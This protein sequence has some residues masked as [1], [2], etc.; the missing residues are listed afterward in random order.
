MEKLPESRRRDV[1]A[2]D[3]K[4]SSSDTKRDAPTI[5]VYRPHIHPRTSLI[6]QQRDKQP[7][8]TLHV[9]FTRKTRTWTNRG[10]S[11]TK[12]L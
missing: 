1:C 11:E 7:N 5:I 3:D 4:D 10:K 2:P 12:K 9:F 6:N 8:H